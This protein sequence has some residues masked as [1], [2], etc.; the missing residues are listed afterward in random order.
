MNHNYLYIH[1]INPIVFSIGK[2]HI[3]WYGLM[4]LITFFFIMYF[5]KK[6]SIKYKFFKKNEFENLLNI[7]FISLLIGG[8][9]GH[10]ILYDYKYYIHHVISIFKIWEGG[11]SF[12]GGLIGSIIGIYYFCKKYNKKFFIISDFTSIFIPIGLG[13]GRIGNFINGELWGKVYSTNFPIYCF[14]PKSY[15]YDVK[16]VQKNTYLQ[17]FLEKF[18]YLPRHPSQI[19]EFFLEGI[20]LFIILLYTKKITKKHGILSS[21]FLIIYGIFRI[22]IEFFREPDYNIYIKNISITSGQFFSIPMII[23]GLYIFIYSNKKILKKNT[24]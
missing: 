18:H 11:M 12:H 6:K 16:F 4:Y 9:I 19:Y 5:G 7:I 8:R 23:L 21:V 17:T 13:M 24:K 20:I 14:F 10:V 15:Y 22:F 1:N 3:Y 2:I